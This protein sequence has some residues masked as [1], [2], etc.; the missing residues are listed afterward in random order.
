M[1][2][3]SESVEGNRSGRSGETRG[4]AHTLVQK[5]AAKSE[6]PEG[7]DEK[8][9]GVSGDQEERCAGL[10]SNSLKDVPRPRAFLTTGSRS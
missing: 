7:S 3:L 10:S 9:V 6:H 4:K 5:R 1:S 2:G 8:A